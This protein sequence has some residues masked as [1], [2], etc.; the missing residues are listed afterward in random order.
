MISLTDEQARPL[1]PDVI[2]PVAEAKTSTAKKNESN[3][4][5]ESEDLSYRELQEEL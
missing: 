1:L 3:S 2:E 4:E 5:D